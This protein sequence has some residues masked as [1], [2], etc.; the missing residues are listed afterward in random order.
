MCSSVL[1][2]DATG[3]ARD[4]ALNSAAD[5]G[6]LLCLRLAMASHGVVLAYSYSED[7]Y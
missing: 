4:V 5:G 1:S 2:S 6:S 3:A 7:G